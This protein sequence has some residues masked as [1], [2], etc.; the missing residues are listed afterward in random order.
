MFNLGWVKE[1]GRAKSIKTEDIML[2]IN[3]GP[4]YS[5]SPLLNKRGQVVGILSYM[6]QDGTTRYYTGAKS[7][8]YLRYR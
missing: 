6:I 7:I 4:G 5:G 2:T 8:D 3:S 1:R